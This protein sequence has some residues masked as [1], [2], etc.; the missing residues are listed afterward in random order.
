MDSIVIAA[1]TILEWTGPNADSRYADS[2]AAILPT[3]SRLPG[4]APPSGTLEALLGSGDLRL[5]Q[6]DSL[7]AALASFPSRLAGMHRT[8]GFGAAALFN[9]YRP[10]L[11]ETVPMRVFGR[12]GDGRS[13]F[14]RGTTELLR[15]LEFENQ[16]QGRLTNLGFLR[17]SHERM[18]ELLA[19]ILSMLE[20]EL[21]R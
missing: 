11:N 20:A 12:G 4:F 1:E 10:Y 13:A 17:T 5:I 14:P 6:N 8:E 16:V 21:S 7:R 3:V 2:L 9:D 15:S 19:Q 18:G